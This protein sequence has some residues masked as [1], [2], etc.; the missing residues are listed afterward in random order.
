MQIT[1]IDFYGQVRIAFANNYGASIIRK[2]GS[3]GYGQGF[4][5]IGVLHKGELTYDTPITDDVLGFVRPEEVGIYLQKI[6][7]LPKKD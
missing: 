6:S 1:F 7:E 4:F 3:Y 2:P 5:E